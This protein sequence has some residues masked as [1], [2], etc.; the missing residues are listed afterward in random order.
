MKVAKKGQQNIL[1]LRR[2][3]QISMQGHLAQWMRIFH[4]NFGANAIAP[5]FRRNRSVNK[6]GTMDFFQSGAEFG[7]VLSELRTVIRQVLFSPA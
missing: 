1:I 2:F 4:T 3:R 7:T 5:I 6:S